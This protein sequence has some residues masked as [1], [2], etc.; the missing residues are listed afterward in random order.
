MISPP[1]PPDERARLAALRFLEIL[2]TEAEERFDRI[3]QL[4]SMLLD[5]PICVVSLVD[6]ER[7]WFK[8][9]HGLDA[10]ETSREVSF[11]GH[12]ILQDDTMVV[13]DATK[14]ERF[15]DNPL[16]LNDPSIRFYAGH[17]LCTQA[18]HRVGTLCVIDRKPRS[19]DAPQLLVLK[20]LA[21]VIESE[22][23]SHE[24]LMR[25]T[26]DLERAN[27]QIVEAAEHKATF[28]ANMSH[29]IRTPMMSILGYTDLINSD[30]TTN[31]DR[32]EY[33]SIIKTSGVH[34]LSLINDIL[35][36]SKV[37]AGKMEVERILVDLPAL[38]TDVE[39]LMRMRAREK[40]ISV[41]LST[42]GPIPTTIETDP[43]R[44]RQVLVN[45]VGNAI[46]FTDTGFVEIKARIDDAGDK[47]ALAIDV[48]DTGIGMTAK[49]LAKIFQP[50]AQAEAAT[51]RRFGGTG[52][53]LAISKQLAALLGGDIT[54]ESTL[55]VGTTFTLR[56]DPGSLEGVERIGTLAPETPETQEPEATDEAAFA[57]RILVA[58]DDPVNRRLLA[59][60]LERYDV[61]L[62]TVGDGKAAVDA[63]LEASDEGQPFDLVLMDMLMPVLDGYAAASRLRNRGYRGHIVALTGNTQAE[64]R[65]K[66]LLSGCDEYLAKPVDRDA[67]QD[68]LDR[69]AQA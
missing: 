27:R 37:E 58:E 25:Y 64:D 21:G 63:V 52:L 19:L 22:L 60:I 5:T 2:D 68:L 66:C 40:C 7:Q 42:A 43:V 26:K 44:L 1:P 18:G 9:R 36:H 65:E 8:S 11:C 46:K 12:T 47:D 56:V 31:E 62:N 51:T 41:R 24:E 13:E 34:L 14:D 20:T 69:F 4:A 15:G 28:L 50:F 30:D 53:G 10:P 67:L 39:R 23:R 55:G 49:Q 33:A 54:V 61:E 35:D 48:R 6:S 17:P 16:V 32:R 29:E 3:T 38:L 59:K 57:G 45:L